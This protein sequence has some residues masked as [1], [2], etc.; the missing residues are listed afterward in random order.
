MAC[1]LT[2]WD[3]TGAQGTFLAKGEDE[4]SGSAAISCQQPLV[5]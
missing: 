3:L 5:G 4:S 1:V 2:T